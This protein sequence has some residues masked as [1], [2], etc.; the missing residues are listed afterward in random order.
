MSE[1]LSFDGDAARRVE[2]TYLTP[3]IVAQRAEVMADLAPQPGESVLDIGVGPGLLAHDLAT[4]VGPDG[5]VLGI[6]ASEAMVEMTR[7]RCAEQPWARFEVADACDLPCES[8]TVHRA[9][10]T[11]VYEY[12]ADMPK[13]LAELHRVLAPGG[14]ALILDTDYDSFVLRSSDAELTKRIVDAWDAHFVHR[15]LPRHLTGLLRE[16]GFEIEMRRVMPLLNADYHRDTFSYGLVRVMASFAASQGVEE[17][18]TRRWVEG[19]NELGRQGDYF[20]SL[21]RYLFL[22][23]KP[24]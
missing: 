6:D 3:D 7:R 13:A 23:R 14:R 2:R 20:F 15:D 10:S 5:A 18:E 21:N 8:G 24:E 1:T 22:A 17:S 19:L 9:V 4:A 11:Q 12:V 16:A